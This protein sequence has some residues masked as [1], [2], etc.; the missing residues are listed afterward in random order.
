[1]GWFE[2]QIH[3]RRANDDA[4]L[5]RAM[6]DLSAAVTGKRPGTSADDGRTASDAVDAVLAYYGVRPTE[7]PRGVTGLRDIVDYQLRPTGIRYRT[8]RLPKGW[9]KDAIGALLATTTDGVPVA[10]VPQRGGYCFVDPATG[11]KV[12]VNERSAARLSDEAYCFY[13][14]LPLKELAVRDI[15]VYMFRCLDAADYVLVALATLAATLLGMLLPAVNQVLFGPVVES[16]R[17]GLLLPIVALLLGATVSQA[18]IGGAKSLVLSRIDTKL[19]VA[20]EAAAMM[21]VLSLPAPFFKQYASGDLASRLTSIRAIAAMIENIVLN[22]ALTSVFSLAYI[23]Q[24]FAIAPSLALPALLVILVNVAVGVATT[25]LQIR[26]SRKEL[27]YSAELSGWQYSLIGGIQKIKLARAE[28]RAFATWAAIYQKLVRITYNGP[29]AVR[30]AATMQTAVSLVGTALIHLVAVDAGVTVSQYMAF[31]AAFGM[32]SGSF[33][34]LTGVAGSIAMIKPH[35]DMAAPILRTLPEVSER[36]QVLPRIT[37][38]FELD[39]VTFSYGGGQAPII[40]GLSLKVRPGQYVAVVGR[41]GCG[42]STLMRLLLGFEAPPEG[43]G[44]LRRVRPGEPRRGEP[45][46]QHRRRPAERQAVP[47]RHLFQH[48]GERPVADTRRRLG[49]SRDGRHRRRH[50]RDAHGHAH[51]DLG[52][53]GRRLGRPAPAPHDR[54]RHRAQAQDPHVR[55]GHERPGQRDPAH[56]ERQPRQAQVHPRRHRAPPLDDPHLQPHPR[57]RRR[58]HRRGRHLRGAHGAWRHLPRARGA[59]ARVGERRR[60]GAVAATPPA[61]ARI[62]PGWRAV[63]LRP[64]A[65]DLRAKSRRA[66]QT[67]RQAASEEKLL[68][69]F[70]SGDICNRFF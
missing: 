4:L 54:P 63:F 36:R 37:G 17:A 60:R 44:L 3:E 55:R 43:C 24:V 68:A 28:R 40:D 15:L 21:R 10:L 34:A 52:G 51:D 38:A 9:Y 48:R 35:L 61:A 26:V 59:P 14:P 64:C 42:K 31:S 67:G 70:A 16:G 12:R 33:S 69:N 53:I 13:R 32:V 46:P 41:T 29:L 56:R 11:S 25:L 2:S 6:R 50:P 62:R 7:L 66:A 19:S 47:G 8:V 5:D 65:G 49:G 23:G 27:E 22:T 30:L 18:L 58:P 45:A 20:V 39:N 1:M 57:A